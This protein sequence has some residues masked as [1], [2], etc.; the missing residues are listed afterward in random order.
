[1]SVIASYSHYHHTII[2]SSSHH[3]HRTVLAQ[4]SQNIPPQSHKF[5]SESLKIHRPHNSKTLALT[6]PISLLLPYR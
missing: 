4:Y 1:M 6:K 3:H 5:A 2:T